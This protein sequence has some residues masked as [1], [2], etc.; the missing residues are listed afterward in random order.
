MSASPVKCP[1]CGSD[2]WKRYYTNEELEKMDN[3]V[4]MQLM[5]QAI[6]N[7]CEHIWDLS[8]I[9]IVRHFAYIKKKEGKT[10]NE[11]IK[12]IQDGKE[13]IKGE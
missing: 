11:I 2:N 12:E 5:K 8:I 9:E 3:M 10:D 7:E 6:C 13:R 4:S 1:E